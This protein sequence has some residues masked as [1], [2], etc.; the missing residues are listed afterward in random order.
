MKLIPFLASSCMIFRVEREGKPNVYLWV[1][2]DRV[3]VTNFYGVASM[4]THDPE[5]VPVITKEFDEEVDEAL[6]KL[7]DFP[8]D[9][10]AEMFERVDEGIE[11]KKENEDGWKEYCEWEKYALDEVKKAEEN[12]GGEVMF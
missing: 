9:K 4:F 10:L 2:G 3:K 7:R 5:P 8:K 1:D 12:G 6:E 11:H